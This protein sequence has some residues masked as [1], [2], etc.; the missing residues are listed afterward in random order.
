MDTGLKYGHWLKVKLIGLKSNC[1]AIGSR[2]TAHYGGLRQAQEVLSQSSFYSANDSRLHFGL[3]SAETADLEIRWTNGL[4]E[5]V[6]NV[7]ANR[8]VVI[9]EGAGIVKSR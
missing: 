5:L 8:L 2:V 6:R 3:G 7:P 4:R 1:S 9:K